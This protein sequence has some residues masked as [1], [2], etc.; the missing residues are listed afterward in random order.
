MIARLLLP[1]L[2]ALAACAEGPSTVAER[3]A[4]ATAAAL[5]PMKLF[6]E[7]PAPATDRSNRSIARDFLDLTFSLESGTALPVFT[8]FEG[9]ITIRVTG[10]APPTLGPDLNRLVGRLRNEAGIDIRGAGPDEEAS[11]TVDVV[12]RGELQRFLPEA[13]CVVVPNVS[14]WRDYV[15]NR[16][17][18]TIEWSRIRARTRLAVII[19][20]DTSPQEI[21]TCLHEE[22]AQALGPVNDLFRLTDSV[23]NDDDF[24]SVLTGFDMAILRAVYAPELQTGMTRADVAARLPAVLA[25]TNP[26]GE[27]AG[28]GF[29][30]RTPDAWRDA[31]LIAIDARRPRERRID[32]ATDAVG[33]A[34]RLGPR[35]PHLAYALYLYGRLV[36]ASEPDVAL[37]AFLRAGDIYR[38]SPE[39]RL[40]SANV[41]MQIAGSA[42]SDGKPEVAID[43]ADEAIPV[44]ARAENAALLSLLMLIK[45]EAL[46][47]QGRDTAAAA[48]RRDALGWGR[49]AFGSDAAV[50]A[51][52]AEIRGLS[53]LSLDGGAA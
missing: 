30:R 27:R 49:Y 15:A 36:L 35:D 28:S 8:R 42:L 18:R 43:I 41:A 6:A 33:I 25:R 12:A 26:A 31:I 39:T 5:P 24:H 38:A 13:A 46:R 1:A 19:P 20:G 21:R 4:P 9:P 17:S 10:S 7:R 22:V 48:V 2:L 14:S 52:A 23:F 51:R 37:A 16:R 53:P 50:R 11:I 45:A 47:L 44:A 29:R 32:A 40:Q 34:Q 3:R